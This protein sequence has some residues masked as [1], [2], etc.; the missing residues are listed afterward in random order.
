LIGGFASV[1]CAWDFGRIG[2][3]TDTGGVAGVGVGVDSD[4]GATA[5]SAHTGA[6]AQD[7]PIIITMNVVI[8]DRMSIHQPLL[9]FNDPAMRLLNCLTHPFQGTENRRANLG[10]PPSPKNIDG[11]VTGGDAPAYGQNNLIQR[12]RDRLGQRQ[13]AINPSDRQNSLIYPT[14]FTVLASVW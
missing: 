1:S 3:G 5:S 6:A 11:H 2:F 9:D 14:L 8:V 12:H 10:H 7:N 4:L 13:P